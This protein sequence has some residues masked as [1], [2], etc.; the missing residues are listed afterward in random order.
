MPRASEI[1]SEEIPAGW[2]AEEHQRGT[3][4]ILIVHHGETVRGTIEME[5]YEEKVWWIRILKLLNLI[6]VES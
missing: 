6:S 4:E 3:K 2:W 5:S 1:T